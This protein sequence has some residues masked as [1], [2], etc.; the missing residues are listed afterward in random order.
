MSKETKNLQD[1]SENDSVE[2]PSCWTS[3]TQH[4]RRRFRLAIAASHHC[5]L[6]LG[7]WFP[8]SFPFVFVVGY[9]KSG[10]SWAS[11]MIADCLHLPYPQHAVLPLGFSAVLQTHTKYS[12]DLPRSVYVIR[13][14]RDV[15]VSLYFHLAANKQVSQNPSI[16]RGVAGL[17]SSQTIRERLPEFIQGQ[18]RRP[19]SSSLNWG[20]HVRS[21]FA[22]D[23]RSPLI[24]YEDLREHGSA[25]LQR[26]VTTLTGKPVSDQTLNAT[27]DRFSFQRLAGRQPGKHDPQSY[28]RSGQS[29]EWR[30]YFS[31]D[32][33]ETFQEHFG[34]GLI[35]GGYVRDDSWVSDL[36]MKQCA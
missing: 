25:T 18:A 16:Y 21:F 3:A 12:P 27:L 9:P 36:D 7:K 2:R 13:D 10:T 1:D 15:M 17:S 26:V 6:W 20:D 32:A 8:K 19:F 34:E 33:A 4:R 22:A 35:A 14:G 11:Q 28:L 23:M 31:R 5:N 24:R 30:K 29:G